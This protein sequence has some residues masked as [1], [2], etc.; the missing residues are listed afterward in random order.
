[1]H[2]L[3][4]LNLDE[5]TWMGS[6]DPSFLGKLEVVWEKYFSKNPELILI[7]CGSVSQ[8]IEENILSSTGYFG[9][10][11]WEISLEELSLKSC[12]QL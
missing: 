2:F 10:V 5:I 7:L 4:K 1:M 6:L 12:D 8:W 3:R 11:A 9:R